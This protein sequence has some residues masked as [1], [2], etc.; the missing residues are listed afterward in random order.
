M[1]HIVSEFSKQVKALLKE[2]LK[3]I[4]LFGSRARGEGRADSDIDLLIVEESDLPRYKR[5]ARYYRALAGICVP[6][7]VV[8]WTPA[9]I[10]DWSQV[11]NA[12]ITTAIREGKTVYAK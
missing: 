1:D 2:N 10:A 9:E 7:D 5:G 12:F 4:V 8:V 6:K 11:A 3:L